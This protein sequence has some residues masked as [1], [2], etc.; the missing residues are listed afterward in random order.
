MPEGSDALVFFGA[1]GDLANKQ[2]IPA[3]QALVGRGLDIPIIGVARRA[4][5]NEQFVARARESLEQHGGLDG[6]AFAKMAR[7]MRYVSGDY[8]DPTTY[9]RLRQVLGDADRPLHYLAIPPNLFET[10]ARG[11]AGV[12]ATARARVVIE[13]PFGRDLLSAQELNRT[14]LQFCHE[15]AIFRID[16]YLGKEPVENLSYFRFANMFLEPIW[17]RTYI[18]NIQ[19]TMAES[20]GVE[21]RGA[22]YDEAGAIRDVVQ[23]H[24]L[25]VTALLTME[26]PSAFALESGRDQ[27]AL[28]LKAIRPL[29]PSDVVR[30]QFRGYRDE[31]G[32]APDSDVETFAAIRLRVENWRWAGVPI[33]IPAG[34]RLPTTTTEIYV[35]MK[36]APQVVFAEEAELATQH[37]GGANNVRFRLS[38]DVFISIGALAKVPGDALRGESVELVARHEPI[39]VR[40]PYERLLGDAMRGDQRLFAREDAIEAA[41]RVVDPIVGEATPLYMYEPNTWGPTEANRIGPPDGWMEP[42][43]RAA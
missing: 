19:I 11:L 18:N 43:C 34:K 17:N 10:V 31:S 35:Q 9:R 40:S 41:W 27:K 4:L 16:H 12:G 42:S 3:L 23:N 15:D 5:T 13:K 36:H 33:F 20:F 21:G 1:T 28:V 37:A 29:T 39:G 14:L 30:G 26:P 22:Y 2:V 6:I 24:L 32:V 8:Q 25:Q 38:P 7:L